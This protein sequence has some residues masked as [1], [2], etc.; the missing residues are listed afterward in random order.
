MPAMRKG[1]AA[2][3]ALSSPKSCCIWAIWPICCSMG[4]LGC[5]SDIII[6]ALLKE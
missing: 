2:V 4:L 3:V 1:S 6:I 5:T